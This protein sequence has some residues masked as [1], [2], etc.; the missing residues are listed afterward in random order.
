MIDFSLQKF[1]GH[2]RRTSR[3]THRGNLPR[4]LILTLNFDTPLARDP[5]AGWRT[6]RGL[7]LRQETNTCSFQIDRFKSLQPTLS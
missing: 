7:S 6:C 2:F 3:I 1:L 5:G 4:Q